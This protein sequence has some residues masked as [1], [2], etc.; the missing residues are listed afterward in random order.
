MTLSDDRRHSALVVIPTYDERENVTTVLDHVLAAADVDVL[1]VDDSSPDGTAAVVRNHPRYGR[2]VHLLVRQEKTGLGGAYRAGFAWALREDYEQI[3]QMDADLSHPP[4]V[5]PQLLAALEHADV[6]I[7]SRYVRGGG[8]REWSL[9]RRAI[10]WFGNLYVRLLLGLPVRDATAGFR[11]F[12]ADAL[13][14]IDVTASRAEGYGF[15]I[16]TTWNAVRAGLRITEVPIIFTDR[17]RGTSKMTT[18]IALEALAMVWRWRSA[19]HPA[20]V[21]D[22]RLG[23]PIR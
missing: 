3:V 14:R 1:V 12:D 5:V 7:G 2:R 16:E 10:S 9:L 20:P 23:V 17:A 19:G 15:Q 8:V 21:D 13:R 4:A 18:A 22:A 11:A 6:A